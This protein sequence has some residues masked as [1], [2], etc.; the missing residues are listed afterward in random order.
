MLTYQP[1]TL[2]FFTKRRSF[3]LYRLIIVT[4]RD[5]AARRADTEAW[6]LKYFP[7]V[8]D[9]IWFSGDSAALKQS[10]KDHDTTGT[11][12]RLEGSGGCNGN[13]IG[14][15]N[16][17]GSGK[18]KGKERELPVPK[19]A[20]SK[21]EVSTTCLPASNCHGANDFPTRQ[22]VRKTNS[23]FLID[24]S[25]EHAL[26]LAHSSPPIKTILL[27]THRWSF[28]ES[29]ARTAEDMLSYEERV[30]RG[31]EL[32]PEMD[33]GGYEGVIGR[34]RDWEELGVMV[35]RGKW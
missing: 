8:F 20:G 27:G 13:G 25:L 28:R 15:G 19:V 14:N 10:V 32:P 4:A 5:E 26:D 17:G 31:M 11:I 2:L 7:G 30:G 33:L 12:T 1:R 23:L 22:I 35:W 3:D 18:G 9:E 29:R 24:D 34:A 16:G 6:L 21:A